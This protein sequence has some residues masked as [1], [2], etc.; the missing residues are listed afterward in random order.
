VSDTDT[1]QPVLPALSRRLLGRAAAGAAA[2]ATVSGGLVVG[3]PS[4]ALAVPDRRRR[5][6][7]H[8]HRH[9][10]H[11]APPTSTPPVAI[12]PAPVLDDRGLLVLERFTGGWAPGLSDEVAAVG[13][14]DRWFAAQLDPSGS[15]IPDDFYTSSA[16]W[17]ISLLA[18]TDQLWARDR[19]GTEGIWVASANYERWSMLRRMYSARQV[20]ETMASFWEHHLHVPVDADGVGLF[21]SDYGQMVRRHALGRFDDLLLEA[22]THPAMGVYLGNAVSTKRAPNENLGRELLELHTVGRAAGYTEDDVKAS[23]R[24]LTGYRVDEWNTWRV[25]YDPNAHWTGPVTVLGF[26]DPN[27]STDGRAV[28]S[29]YLRYLAHHPS[30]AR[31]IARKLAV[32]FVSDDPSAELVDHLA[33]VYLANDTAIVPVLRA[34][35]SSAEFTGS[36][37]AKMR[38]PDED[39]VATY[40]A[41]GARVQ[42]PT[43]G[44]SAANAILWQASSIGLRP[45]GWTR[46]DGRP[47]RAEAWSSVSRILNSFDVHYSMA[48]RWWPTRD[49]AYVA[50]VDWLPAGAVTFGDLVDALSRKIL[51]RPATDVL[52][53]AAAQATGCSAT[54]V[55]TADHGLVRWDMARLLTVFLDAPTHFTR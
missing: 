54:E 27:A 3:V 49:V 22:T 39:V 21:R 51:G 20:L 31:T 53:T 19:D 12:T 32:R 26:S 47:D 35:V 28:T 14:I 24:I 36:A 48:G 34:L 38:T 2:T 18:T 37:G 4:A 8:K 7:R 42:A 13:G 6:R 25:Y 43:S 50:P 17:W 10:H 41:L 16:S 44:S 9:R 45:Y 5:K 40:R 52:R 46:P 29:A 23:A 1:E 30:T 33:Q 55:I 15:G 11:P